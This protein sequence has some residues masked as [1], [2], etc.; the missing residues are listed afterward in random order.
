MKKLIFLLTLLVSLNVSA[1][2]KRP[3]ILFVFS[4]DH[5]THAIGAY[6]SLIHI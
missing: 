6:L 4:D 5:A 3:N 2:D 1:K